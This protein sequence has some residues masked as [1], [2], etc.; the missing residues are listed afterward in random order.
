MSSSLRTMKLTPMDSMKVELSIIFKTTNHTESLDIQR[1]KESLQVL[2]STHYWPLLGTRDGLSVTEDPNGTVYFDEQ[3]IDITVQT[4]STVPAALKKMKCVLPDDQLFGVRLTECTDGYVM[5]VSVWHA[6]C[7]GHSLF[8]LLMKDWSVVY[9]GGEV[10]QVCH[11]RELF[12]VD[13]PPLD[14]VGDIIVLDAFDGMKLE[15]P[16]VDAFNCDIL[17]INAEKL[18]CFKEKHGLSRQL[19]LFKEIRALLPHEELQFPVNL[20][21]NEQR[22]SPP[23]PH[24]YFGNA[25]VYGLCK[26]DEHPEDVLAKLTSD[27]VQSYYAALYDQIPEDGSKMVIGSFSALFLNGWMYFDI[28]PMFGEVQFEMELKHITW[29]DNVILTIDAPQG[30]VYIVGTCTNIE[31]LEQLLE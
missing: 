21:N 2:V 8:N 25:L 11:D 4:I 18:N 10:E 14:D 22:W 16:D 6:L 9:A 5:G 3:S 24:R 12:R 15:D 19:S 27:H 20:R 1:L 31:T 30:G 26:A 28:R 13:C 7:D 29:M 17:E 23:I